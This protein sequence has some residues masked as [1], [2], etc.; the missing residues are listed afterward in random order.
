MCSYTS[1]GTYISINI[2]SICNQFC[3]C[4]CKYKYILYRATVKHTN[5][6][7]QCDRVHTTLQ[8]ICIAHLGFHLSGT[9]VN[10]E[11]PVNI[12]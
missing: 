12:D 1:R 2:C 7:K 3:F 4:P 5:T 6:S 9:A 8:I 11:M 10:K